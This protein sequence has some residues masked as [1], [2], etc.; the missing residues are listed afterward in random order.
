[1]IAENIQLSRDKQ[2]VPDD[3]FDRHM[4]RARVSDIECRKNIFD[5]QSDKSAEREE[6]RRNIKN[7]IY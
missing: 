5:N 6:A 7:S 1:M 3:K 2:L 4:E